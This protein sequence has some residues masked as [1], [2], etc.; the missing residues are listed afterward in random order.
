MES[1]RNQEE[2]R[3]GAAAF[4]LRLL[5][6]MKRPA[7]PDEGASG[8]TLQPAGRRTGEGTESLAPYLHHGRS[9]RP[10]PLE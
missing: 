1:G 2:I 5:Q 8:D 10:G 9:T 4:L 6:K 7:V 3:D